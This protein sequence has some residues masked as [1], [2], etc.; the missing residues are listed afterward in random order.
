MNLRSGFKTLIS[1]S[2]L[3]LV[4][5]L[6]SQDRPV[7]LSSL[8]AVAQSNISAALGRD[9]SA[10]Q[11]R[12]QNSGIHFDSP[13]HQFAADFTASGVRLTV[14]RTSFQMTFEAYGRGRAVRSVKQTIPD[15]TGNRVTYRHGAI[16]EWYVN[17]PMGLEQGFT[18]KKGP[19]GASGEP[20]TIALSLKDA[21][22][23]VDSALG[24]ATFSDGTG[25]AVLR[26]AGL[27]AYDADGKELDSRLESTRD[28][29]E[30]EIADKEARYPIVVDPVME[31]AT[32]TALGGNSGD[33]FGASVAISGN[34]IAVGAPEADVTR[35]I[36]YVFVKPASGW[37]NMTQTAELAASGSSMMGLYAF[38]GDTIVGGQLSCTGNGNFGPGALYVY[39]KPAG[40]WTNMSNP[41]ATLADG[42]PG[43]VDHFVNSATMNQTQDIIVAGTGVAPKDNVFIFARPAGGWTNMGHATTVLSAPPGAVNFGSSVAMFSNL[44]AVGASGTS[45]GG[46]VFLFEA[47]RG[48]AL[49]QIAELTPSNGE[50]APGIGLSLTMTRDTIVTG[51]PGAL[52]NQGAVYV[53]EKPSTGWTNMTE[54]AQLTFANPP[55]FFNVL[56]SSVGIDPTGTKIVAGILSNGPPNPVAYLYAKPAGGWQ[57]TSSPTVQLFAN[58]SGEP[59]NIAGAVAISSTNIV[60]GEAGTN[61]ETGAAFV[62][63]P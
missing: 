40:G 3:L 7:S 42:N 24:A 37:Q 1:L 11:A 41:T 21:R 10:Y 52:N 15:A 45:P 2:F 39:V 61:D 16:S 38:S 62:F 6:W 22:A 47:G 46:A 33:V 12:P 58:G 28:G 56:G 43:C 31:L 30:I 9:N 48:G 57:T 18:I 26:Y 29:M 27:V 17:G 50:A 23:V 14:G 8:P 13:R 49:T 53:F 5:S 34:T 60:V 63:G 36:I 59:G 54:T 55:G 25:K 51:A 32:L 20:L 44:L 35:G 4:S 19:A